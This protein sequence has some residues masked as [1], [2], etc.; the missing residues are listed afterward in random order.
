MCPLFNACA[1]PFCRSGQQA[2]I[3]SG[4]YGAPGSLGGL[5]NVING[6]KF[7]FPL[8][9][10]DKSE[11]RVIFRRSSSHISVFHRDTFQ[12]ISLFNTPL[13]LLLHACANNVRCLNIVTQASTHKP[14]HTGLHTQAS[15]HKLHNIKRT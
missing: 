4:C 3:R 2:T 8:L 15:T 11:V 13:A 12:L 1:K 10:G 7:T 6:P 9:R 14:P 5:F